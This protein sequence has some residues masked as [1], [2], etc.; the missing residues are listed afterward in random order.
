MAEATTTAEMELGFDPEG[1][2]RRLQGLLG[3]YASSSSSSVS[4]DVVDIS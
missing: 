3:D 1:A 4:G 2:H